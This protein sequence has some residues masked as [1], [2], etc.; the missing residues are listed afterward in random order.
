[1]SPFLEDFL[2]RSDAG[3][4][5]TWNINDG[6]VLSTHDFGVAPTDWHIL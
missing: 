4:V 2:R 6:Q 5:A 3:T 1:M